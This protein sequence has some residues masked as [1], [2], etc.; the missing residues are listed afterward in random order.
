[1]KRALIFALFLSFIITLTACNSESNQSASTNKNTSSNVLGYNYADWKT[2]NDSSKEKELEE[3]PIYIRATFTEKKKIKGYECFFAKASDG[4]WLIGVQFFKDPDEIC[5]KLKDKDLTI[6]GVY[7]GISET[8]HLPVIQA[9]YIEFDG[10]T[11]KSDIN[12]SVNKGFDKD[13]YNRFTQTTT[14]TAKN[15]L[16]T[17]YLNALAKAEVY[18]T[19]FNM[20]KRAI[21]KQLTSSFEGF[22]QDAAQYAIDNL[23]A[24][25]KANALAK[26]KVYSSDFN[27]SKNAIYK[28]LTS[29]FEQFT[30]D[31]AQYAIDNLN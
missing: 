4:D 12:Y 20:S 10:N 9:E 22:T 3:T 26:A 18:S 11:L 15:S 28:Q 29:D 19:D 6:Y 31:E 21:F 17:E 16:P 2:Y 13:V 27:M 5:N 14:T 30:A 25:Y 1:M 24:D 7:T 8:T 23:V